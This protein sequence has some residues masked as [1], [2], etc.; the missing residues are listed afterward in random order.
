VDSPADYG[1]AVCDVVQQLSA[2]YDSEVDVVDQYVHR[3]D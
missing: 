3:F 2:R 1:H